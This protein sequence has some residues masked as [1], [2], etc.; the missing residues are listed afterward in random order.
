[1]CMPYPS[2]CY[3]ADLAGHFARQ[4]PAGVLRRLSCVLAEAKDGHH[5]PFALEPD[6]D[7]T[8]SHATSDIHRPSLSMLRAKQDLLVI[9]PGWSSGGSAILTQDS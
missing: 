7:Q 6:S 2:F 1:M 4:V 8:S 3:C 9:V 5:L